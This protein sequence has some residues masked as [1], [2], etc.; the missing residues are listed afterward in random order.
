LRAKHL[1]LVVGSVPRLKCVDIEAVHAVLARVGSVRSAGVGCHGLRCHSRGGAT[2]V[3]IPGQGTA[4]PFG[5]GA[6]F[7]AKALS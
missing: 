7:R 1:F 2:A 3:V 5:E 4:V 6:T